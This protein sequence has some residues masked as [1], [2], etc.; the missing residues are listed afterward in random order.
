MQNIKVIKCQ[1][2]KKEIKEGEALISR[3][4]YRPGKPSIEPI[5]NKCASETEKRIA[6]MVFYK[7]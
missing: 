3:S 5:H 6:D 4:K 1:H 2:C 7:V